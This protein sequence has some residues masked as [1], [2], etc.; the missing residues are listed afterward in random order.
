[1]LHIS[2]LLRYCISIVYCKNYYRQKKKKNPQL[3]TPLMGYVG[4]NIGNFPVL[5]INNYLCPKGGA[6][7]HF[8]S[9]GDSKKHTNILI[10]ATQKCAVA[11]ALTRMNC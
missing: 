10:I 3:A 2:I 11:G 4:G 6:I 1:M 8:Q 7:A 9:Q 5:A